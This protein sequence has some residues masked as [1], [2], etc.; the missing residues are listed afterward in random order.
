MCFVSNL[1]LGKKNF[2]WI[3]FMCHIFDKFQD[4]HEYTKLKGSQKCFSVVENFIF[5]LKPSKCLLLQGKLPYFL[6]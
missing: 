4:A 6:M 1:T 3:I 5:Y 2:T